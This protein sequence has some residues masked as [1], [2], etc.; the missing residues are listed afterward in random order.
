MRNNQTEAEKI[1]WDYLKNK[2]LGYK[3]TRQYSAGPYILDFY[4]PK[5][6]LAIELDG[7]HHN[8]ENSVLYDKDREEY[9]KA[10]NIKIIRFWNDEVMKDVNKVL[11]EISRHLRYHPRSD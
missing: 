1:L 7:S 6:R 4:C 3:F 10:V 8:E 5:L 11:D 2:K 9:L